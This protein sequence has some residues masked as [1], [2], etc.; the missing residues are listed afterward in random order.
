MGSTDPWIEK[1]R[2]QA[3]KLPWSTSI[4]VGVDNMSELMANSDLAIGAA[5]ST[6][7]ERCFLALP[8]IKSAD[9]LTSQ[10]INKET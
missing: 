10:L 5:G 9:S 3:K 7:W 2:K 8:S 4:K 6:A 1:V